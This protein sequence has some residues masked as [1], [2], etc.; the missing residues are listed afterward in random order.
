MKKLTFVLVLCSLSLISFTQE[1]QHSGIISYNASRKFEMKLQGDGNS[2]IA[3][4]LPKEQKSKKE[5][6]FNQDKSLY[7][8]KV[9]DNEP[10]TEISQETSGIN[11]TV[12]IVEPEDFVFTDMKNKMKIEQREFMSRTFLIESSID[13]MKWKITGNQK[14]ILGYNCLEA[15]LAGAKK[16]TIA[17][18]APE[19][20]IQT[21]PDGFA[22]LPGLILSVDV[23]NGKMSLT[24]SNIDFKEID[25][26]EI[27]R[28]KKG[29][30]LTQQEF[31]KI[32]EEKT[33]E[34][35]TK[36]GDMMIIKTE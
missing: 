15:E 34:L 16:K 17:W 8:N 9:S 27:S 10:E 36:S 20:P 24:A 25:P 28:P 19:I 7:R 29:K 11:W 35:N 4:M 26:R 5:L 13:S 31:D 3:E 30:R 18:F 2:E 22:G 14:K 12:K 1:W 21:G 6:L 32:V 33:K 23:D